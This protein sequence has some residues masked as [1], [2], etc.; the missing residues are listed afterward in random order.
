MV[1][2]E[3]PTLMLTGINRLLSHPTCCRKLG[4]N[5]GAV[6]RQ[7]NHGRRSW[8][9]NRPPMKSLSVL[10]A[11]ACAV[12]ASACGNTSHAPAEPPSGS[13]A[14]GSVRGHVRLDGPAPEN[15][16]IRMSADPMCAK[17]TGGRRVVDETVVA[18]ADG[19]LANVF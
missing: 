15:D 2:T 4:S 1:T 9:N 12:A 14:R 11:V 18:A 16:A 7:L 3:G 19:S 13:V 8:Q 17:A 6:G 10:L 5:G